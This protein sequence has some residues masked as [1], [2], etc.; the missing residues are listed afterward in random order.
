MKE[1]LIVKAKY[2]VYTIVFDGIT[3]ECKKRGSLSKDKKNIF[4]GDYVVFD[5]NELMIT[6]VKERKTLLKRPSIANIDQLLII[7]SL[8]E[9]EF[10]YYLAFKYITYANKY[11]I[12]SKLILTKIDKGVDA[13]EINTIKETFNK[14]G[15]DVYALSNKSLE[16][17]EEVKGLFKNKI[18]CLIGQSGVGKSPCQSRCC[19]SISG[20]LRGSS[21]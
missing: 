11:G 18:S 8:R 10:S 13:E 2:G 12:N 16:G 14:V 15:I 1:G 6:D 7:F 4:V 19:P 20:C 21:C 9:P 3:Y 17:V 5:E